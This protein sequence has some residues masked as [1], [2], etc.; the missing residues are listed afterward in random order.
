VPPAGSGGPRRHDLEAHR[1]PSAGTSRFAWSSRRRSRHRASPGSPIRARSSTRSSPVQKNGLSP[2]SIV[3]ERRYPL[4][5]R[6]V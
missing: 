3:D 5:G 2:R 4:G 1:R 6:A